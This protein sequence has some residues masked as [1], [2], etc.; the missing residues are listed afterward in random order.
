MRVDVME[1]EKEVQAVVKEKLPRPVVKIAKVLPEEVSPSAP[2]AVFAP[3]LQYL[4]FQ[5]ES[6]ARE[7]QLLAEMEAKYNMLYKQHEEFFAQ[8]EKRLI[9]DL[10]ARHTAECR[11]LQEESAAGEKQLLAEL[12][13]KYDMLYKQLEESFAREG[14]QQVEELQA[15]YAAERSRL[16]QSATE[17]EQ[18]LLGRLVVARRQLLVVISGA[19]LSIAAILGFRTSPREVVQPVLPP[20]VVSGQVVAPPVQAPVA[21]PV[22]QASVAKAEPVVAPVVAAAVVKTG[23][24]GNF[25]RGVSS[26]K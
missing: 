23:N 7:K 21:V 16:E 14:K 15:T 22:A 11:R 1:K 17:R 10:L 20:S 19:V 8:K 2:V 25:S 5:E 9:D 26:V 13:V 24:G 3:D 18:A 4:Q 6:A 12:E